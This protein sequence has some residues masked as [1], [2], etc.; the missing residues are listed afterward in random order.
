MSTFKEQLDADMDIFFND[1]GFAESITYNGTE[2]LAD[3]VYNVEWHEDGI[4]QGG[5]TADI[6]T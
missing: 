4:W 1:E 3:S 6:C 2:I 5:P